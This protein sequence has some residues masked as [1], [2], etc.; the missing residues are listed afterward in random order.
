MQIPSNEGHFGF[1]ALLRDATGEVK[2]FNE[3]LDLAT[4]QTP[5]R[6]MRNADFLR[7]LCEDFIVTHTS[8]KVML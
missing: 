7:K 4:R 8:G 2:I 3:A 5:R 1:Y 6:N